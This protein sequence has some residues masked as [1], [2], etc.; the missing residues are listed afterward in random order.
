MVEPTI[1]RLV[2]LP[3]MSPA[4][5]SVFNHHVALVTVDRSVSSTIIFP[6]IKY[7]GVSLQGY[8]LD[9]YIYIY[10]IYYYYDFSFKK[11]N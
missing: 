6:S 9:I 10:I 4:L 8:A 11:R 2:S 7:F 3:T 1:A 5:V